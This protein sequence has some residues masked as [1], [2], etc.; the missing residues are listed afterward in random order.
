MGVRE[1]AE[2]G[3]LISTGQVPVGTAIPPGAL[4][5]KHWKATVNKRRLEK[6]LNGEDMREG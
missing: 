5:N 2:L 3:Y 1:T 6:W 4:G